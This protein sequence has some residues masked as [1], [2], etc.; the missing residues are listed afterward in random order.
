MFPARETA[1]T[2]HRYTSIPLEERDVEKDR[3]SNAGDVED[4][5]AGQGQS[6]RSK[7][8]GKLNLKNTAIKW[9]IDCIT[10]GAILNTTAFLIIWGI[11]KGQTLDKIG[12]N[13][14]TE[15]I[16]IIWNGYKIWPIASIISFSFIPYERRLQFFSF[17]GLC[18]NIYMTIVAA[19]L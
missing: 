9:F 7:R 19:R 13:L 2:K 5:D 6:T 3:D 11:L 14:K 1:T 10:L 15:T 17:V 4:E 16:P 12:H 18:W 8:K